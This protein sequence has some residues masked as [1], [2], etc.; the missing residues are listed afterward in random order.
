MVSKSFIMTLFMTLQVVDCNVLL[1]EIVLK[2]IAENGKK[3]EKFRT[4]AAHTD[5]Y[6]GGLKSKAEEKAN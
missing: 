2:N 3:T 1:S 5:A 6:S 4:R